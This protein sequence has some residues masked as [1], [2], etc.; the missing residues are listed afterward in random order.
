[1]FA[2]KRSVL[3]LRRT[4]VYQRDIFARLARHNSAIIGSETAI[5]YRDIY[6][7]LVRAVDMAENFRDELV[8]AME[9]YLSQISNR[10]NEIM[11]FL[12]VI[13]TLFIP[14]NFLTG[15]FGMNFTHMPLLTS[16]AGFSAM[17]AT[18]GLIVVCLGWYFWRRHWI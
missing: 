2:L 14:L 7:S 4:T 6:D 17:V 1:L 12:T 15:F 11:K 10:L 16:P 3:A 13:S 9:A 8:G 18:M 5:Y